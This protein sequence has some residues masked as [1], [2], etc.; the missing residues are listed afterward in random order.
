MNS[1]DPEHCANND[2]RTSKIDVKQ[3]KHSEIK[4]PPN[5]QDL[6]INVNIDT[7]DNHAQTQLNNNAINSTLQISNE[8]IQQTS[9]NINDTYTQIS[10]P[11]IG[12][13]LKSDLHH[14]ISPQASIEEDKFNNYA[15]ALKVMA[16]DGEGLPYIDENRPCES[17]NDLNI[18]TGRA[19]DF[20]ITPR[21][22]TKI[23]PSL[24]EETG[25][26][27]CKQPFLHTFS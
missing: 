10:K 14:Q 6:K 20:G 24:K 13:F 15:D 17:Y 18:V 26:E 3:A 27:H 16:N 8:S 22:Q 12:R 2:I 4:D 23:L 11:K 25:N 19:C 21:L 7:S 9:V 5:K 1:S